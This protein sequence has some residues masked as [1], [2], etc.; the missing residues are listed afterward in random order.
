MGL[1]PVTIPLISLY[2]W[3]FALLP[4]APAGAAA[5]IWSVCGENFLLM[6]PFRGVHSD[7]TTH[8]LPTSS[9]SLH[10]TQ[11]STTGTTTSSSSLFFKFASFSIKH[12]KW[13]KP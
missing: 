1:A 11:R 5:V 7:V 9:Y 10:A 13:L 4:S 2:V 8:Q 12:K 3:V 6:H